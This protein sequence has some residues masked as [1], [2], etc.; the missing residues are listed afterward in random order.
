MIVPALVLSGGA[1]TRMGSPKALL[2]LGDRTFLARIVGTLLDAGVPEVIVVTGP[3]HD[4]IAAEAEGWPPAW[5]VRL[6]RNDAPG[7]DQASSIRAGLALVD[8]PGVGGVI[9]TLVDHPLVAA[10]TVTRLLAAFADGHPPVA[11]PRVRGRHGHPVV[12]G[13]EAFDALRAPSPD[14]AKSVLRRFAG[15]QRWV[16]VEDEGVVLDIDTPADYER[17][18]ARFA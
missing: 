10:D 5:P 8:R 1:S 14:G 15:R 9:V 11:R 16:D 3:H 13:R 6:V 2:R 18:R 7:A 4:A 12:F 17:A